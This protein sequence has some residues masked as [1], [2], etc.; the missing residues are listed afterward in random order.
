LA[1]GKNPDEVQQNLYKVVTKKFLKKAGHSILL[2]GRY[3]CKARH[4]RGISNNIGME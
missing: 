4:R 1:Y 3:T 2:H